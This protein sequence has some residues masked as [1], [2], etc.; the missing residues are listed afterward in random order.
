MIDEER[1]A[2][3]LEQLLSLLDALGDDSGHGW[4]VTIE[5]RVLTLADRT[6]LDYDRSGALK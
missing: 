2:C 3:E 4:A 5:T 6:A 1:D